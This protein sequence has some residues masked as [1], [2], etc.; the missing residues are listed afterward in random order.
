MNDFFAKGAWWLPATPTE[1]ISGDLKFSQDEG[2]ILELRGMFA[3]VEDFGPPIPIILGADMNG[4][5]YTLR[6]SIMIG[7]TYSLIPTTKFK[8]QE[9]FEGVHASA[10]SELVFDSMIAELSYLFEWA[11]RHGTTFQTTTGGTSKLI[12]EQPPDVDV[13]VDEAL[14]S[15]AFG[16]RV[17]NHLQHSCITESASFF[18]KPKEPLHFTTF[19]DEFAFYLLNFINFASGLR[20]S[21]ESVRF[22]VL[23]ES[24]KSVSCYYQQVGFAKR[25]EKF[26][27]QS[28]LMN[29]DAVG[30]RLDTI[31]TKWFDFVRSIPAVLGLFFRDR[32]HG[33]I[34]LE[35]RLLTLVQALEKYHRD[36]FVSVVVPKDVYG[37]VKRRLLKICPPSLKERIVRC[38][39]YGSEKTLRERLSELVVTREDI[40]QPLVG[41]IDRFVSCA[42]DSRNYYTH[43]S[44]RL[45]KRKLEPQALIALVEVLWILLES[46]L[47]SEVGVSVGE[48]SALFDSYSR[49]Q[50]ARHWSAALKKALEDR[51]PKM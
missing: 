37:P 9:I 35:V 25:K 50:R 46:C 33:N 51:Y 11:N 22:E 21:F 30:D 2:G 45:E 31:L 6:S 4:K 34:T 43:F 27:R 7:S 5:V 18:V 42:T 29:L 10:D 14:V 3:S 20:N 28:M 40:L 44:P 48:Q 36:R 23:G 17:K 8:S 24:P 26:E 19:K 15:I 39:Q 47:L 13:K 32:A 41:N 16:A 38:L 49:Y 12:Y 1:R